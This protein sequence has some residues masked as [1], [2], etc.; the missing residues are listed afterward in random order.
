LV[1]ESSAPETVYPAGVVTLQKLVSGIA[2]DR[3][4]LPQPWHH[5]A[6]ERP[7]D[8]FW[9]FIHDLTLNPRHLCLPRKRIGRAWN[10]Q[11]FSSAHAA[12]SRPSEKQAKSRVFGFHQVPC[13]LPGGQFRL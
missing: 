10:I 2:Q 7:G 13:R 9:P 1:H 5:F 11:D 4:L 12:P 8:E 6:V 3:V